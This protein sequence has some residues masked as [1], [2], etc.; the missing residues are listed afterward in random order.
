MGN[1]IGN[2]ASEFQLVAKK[3]GAALPPGWRLPMQKHDQDASATQQA[4]GRRL[5][6]EQH[7]Q[8]APGVR[9]AKALIKWVRYRHGRK[10]AMF[11]RRMPGFLHFVQCMSAPNGSQP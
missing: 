3:L 6:L 5:A 4:P 8:E 10:C 1:V 7:G 2:Y 9:Q 11:Y